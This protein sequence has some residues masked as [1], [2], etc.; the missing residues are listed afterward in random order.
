MSPDRLLKIGL[1]LLV[2]ITMAVLLDVL[3]TDDDAMKVAEDQA[4]MARDCAKP[5]GAIFGLKNL[6]FCS[7]GKKEEN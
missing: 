4:A 3:P 2:L 6:F 7:A 1:L 5:D